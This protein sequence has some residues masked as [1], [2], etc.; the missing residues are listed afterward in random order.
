MR[1]AVVTLDCQLTF[2]TMLQHLINKVLIN[3]RDSC[4]LMKLPFYNLPVVKII[5]VWLLRVSRGLLA[6][7]IQKEERLWGSLSGSISCIIVIAFLFFTT[8]LIFLIFSILLVRIQNVSIWII[9]FPFV[10]NLLTYLFFQSV[11]Y[12]RM[13]M[14]IFIA[15]YVIIKVW[16][17]CFHFFLHHSH[18]ISS[19]SHSLTLMICWFSL[20]IDSIAIIIFDCLLQSDDF[21]VPF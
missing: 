18:L 9:S 10:M 2:K 21:F 6:E 16:D 5:Y 17:F 7:R 1:Q 4:R 20:Q 3:S 12:L 8:K 15:L 14:T 13:V 19:L 11:N